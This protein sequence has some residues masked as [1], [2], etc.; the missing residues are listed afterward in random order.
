[1]NDTASHGYAYLAEHP[2]LARQPFSSGVRHSGQ[3]SLTDTDLKR[4]YLASQLQ[5]DTSN[6]EVGRVLQS[7]PWVG[8]LSCPSAFLGRSSVCALHAMN[9]RHARHALTS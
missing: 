6:V 7:R 9:L 8:M 1:M 4:A 2:G 5:H 3:P